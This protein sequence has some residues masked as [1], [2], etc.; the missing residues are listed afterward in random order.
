MKAILKLISSMLIGCLLGVIIVIPLIS[1]INGESIQSVAHDLFVDRGLS[2]LS[3]VGTTIIAALVAF[4]LQIIIHE[5]GHLVAGLLTGYKFVSFRFLNWTLIRK[6]GRL[7]WRK[8]E[9][10]GTGGQCLLAPPSGPIE[11]IDTRWYNAGGVLANAITAL[12]AIMPVWV[13]DLPSWLD[14]FLI[15]M[16]I[17]G[18]FIALTNGIPMKMGGVANDG[19]NLFQ[20]EKDMDG[21]LCFCNVL[22]MNAC[23]QEG[24][25]YSEMPRRL[26]FIPKPTDW[27]NAMHV[28]AVLTSATRKQSQHQWEDS[29]ELLTV[30]RCYK[31]EMMVLYQMELEN[32]L[33]L[34][35]LAT[36]RD[37]E[38][39]QH[40]TDDVAK[41]VAR[42]AAT[43]SDKQLTTM[44][45][46]LVLDRDR[47][48]AEQILQ[49]LETERDK[50][51]HQ[52]DVAMSLDLM[53]W[54]LDKRQT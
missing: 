16:A 27:K 20:L 26:F 39:R 38:A 43:Q 48:R 2:I 44:A 12:I 6:D 25:P 15:M 30:A 32:M 52:G 50:Y 47:D 53:R 18:V 13:F 14:I 5:G 45:V 31:G 19:S 4:I 33:T 34:A 1:L 21:K 51:I 41:Y 29:Y 28:A 10:A 9:L 23:N 37:E 35:C 3:I 7:Q 46:A 49:K 24:V 8:F 40:Y 17:T 36:G 42:H 22:E 11:E 54:F